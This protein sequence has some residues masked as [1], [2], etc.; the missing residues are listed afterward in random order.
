MTTSKKN[1]L[2]KNQ[3]V[4]LAT[5]A[6]GLAL[7]NLSEG[8]NAEEYTSP[9]ARFTSIENYA[10]PIDCEVKNEVSGPSGSG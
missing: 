7:C 9:K 8:S 4:H 6:A 5:I 10:Y 2:S 3:Y 1:R